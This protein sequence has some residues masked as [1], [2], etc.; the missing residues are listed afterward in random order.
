MRHCI[1]F[2]NDCFTKI[3]IPYIKQSNS[4]E[5]QEYI[6]VEL[7]YSKNGYFELYNIEIM[8][9]LFSY[10]SEEEFNYFIL[11]TTGDTYAIILFK[12][13][14]DAFSSGHRE[15]LI[16]FIGKYSSFS[17]NSGEIIKSIPSNIFDNYTTLIYIMFDN[18]YVLK[19]DFDTEILHKMFGLLR[20]REI[21]DYGFKVWDNINSNPCTIIKNNSF[22]MDYQGYIRELNSCEYCI[23]RCLPP[24]EQKVVYDE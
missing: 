11:F 18:Y 19:H 24:I 17:M 21:K 1:V 4:L 22:E 12:S 2:I 16:N 6:T 5:Y 20:C 8:K 15:K 13:K 9:S 7:D 23:F 14:E 10:D 3:N